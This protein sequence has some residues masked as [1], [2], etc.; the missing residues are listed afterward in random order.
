VR[1]VRLVLLVSVVGAAASAPA[2][3]PAAQYAVRG[4]GT[5]KD[6]K[7]GLIW[8]QQPEDAQYS[9]EGALLHCAGLALGGNSDWRAPTKLELETLVAFRVAPP[10]PT[11][12]SQVFPGTK[13]GSYWTSTASARNA[14]FAWYITFDQGASY[15]SLVST[16]ASVRCVR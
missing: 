12:D 4:D 16:K 3:A 10:G 9:W 1:R 8:E 14:V 15:S 6:N 7:T 13:A 2:V 11:I 5:V